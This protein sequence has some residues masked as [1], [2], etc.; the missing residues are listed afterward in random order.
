VGLAHDHVE[1][2]G[3]VD[4]HHRELHIAS[5]VRHLID[6]HCHILPG[7]DDGALDLPDSI[8]MARQADADG[9][10]LVCATPH[11]RHDHDVRIA[12]LPGRVG[13][14]NDALLAAGTRARVLPGAEVAETIVERLDDAELRALSLGG[15]GRWLLLEPRP[16]PLSDSLTATVDHLAARGL[17][18]LVAHPERHL[19]PD[20]VDRLAALIGRGALVQATA[21]HFEHGPAAEGMLALARHGVLHVVSSDAHSSHGGRPVR[22]SGALARLA[23][24]EPVGAYVDWIAREAPRAI[25]AGQDIA[26]PFAPVP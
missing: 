3:L 19:A 18:C 13:E 12:E 21:A 14:L 10:T 23:E 11:I 7:V 16:G 2:L 8:A 4:R 1:V 17:R 15:T 22:L 6:L 24:V 20:L 5:F 26:P 25:V 9:V